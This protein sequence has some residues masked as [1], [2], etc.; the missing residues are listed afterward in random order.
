M[1]SAV[2][3]VDCERRGEYPRRCAAPC[4]TSAESGPC[5][6]PLVGLPDGAQGNAMGGESVRPLP[7]AVTHDVIPGNSCLPGSR[8]RAGSSLKGACS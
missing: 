2:R 5:V 7:S 3:D 1:I 4:F 8:R 6:E